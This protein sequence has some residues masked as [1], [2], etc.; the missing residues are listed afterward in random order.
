MAQAFLKTPRIKTGRRFGFKKIFYLFIFLCI[1]G[2]IIYFVF[3]SNFF[4]VKKIIIVNNK[5]VTQKEV[6]DILFPILSENF[7]SRNII[8]F[9]AVD[10]S[11]MLHEKNDKIRTAAIKKK[12]P[13]TLEVNLEERSTEIIWQTQNI[14][15]GI[16]KD[17]IVYLENVNPA[18]ASIVVD[19][20]NVPV[21]LN[22]KIVLPKFVA[23]IKI[24]VDKLPQK[25]GLTIAGLS[26][27][28]TTRELEVKTGQGF[29]VYF[30]TMRSPEAQIDN[31][32]KVIDKVK[33][34]Q[35]GKLY[36]EYVDLRLENKLYY[37]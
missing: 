31:L 33:A 12:W 27:N 7:F 22:S 3:F 11:N 5:N 1:I 15:Y 20:S 4:S 6:E 24:L 35:K 10:A 23:F 19:R 26:I 34:S 21:K 25:T 17:G 14:N 8:F 9:D 30:D 28:E 2:G 29:I 16:D 13:Q 36:L 37:K 18:G 32:I